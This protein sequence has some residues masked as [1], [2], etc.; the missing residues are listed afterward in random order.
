[1][2]GISCVSAADLDSNSI[3]EINLGSGIGGGKYNPFYFSGGDVNPHL[4]LSLLNYG[5]SG[6]IGGHGF[7]HI[8]WN[9]DYLFAD[10]F[11]HTPENH[12]LQ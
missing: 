2:F 9:Y 11:G 1:M 5:Y 8:N 10:L 4:D 12:N 6:G 7:N 3:H